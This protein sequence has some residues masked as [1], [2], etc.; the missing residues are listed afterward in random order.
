MPAL[1]PGRQ[2]FWKL[3]HSAYHAG[4]NPNQ[5]NHG[6]KNGGSHLDLFGDH[7]H[8]SFCMSIGS[9]GFSFFAFRTSL[10]HTMG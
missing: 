10:H 3:S 9:N 5:E 4:K 7:F 1:L 2:V 6:A 8:C